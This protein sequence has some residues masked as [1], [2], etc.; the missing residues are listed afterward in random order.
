MEVSRSTK[1]RM[2]LS[3][4]ASQVP[5]LLLRK[6]KILKLA[7]TT[8]DDSELKLSWDK[9]PIDSLAKKINIFYIFF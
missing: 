4:A 8:S 1:R 9:L 3:E 6:T 5:V 7:G 2:K